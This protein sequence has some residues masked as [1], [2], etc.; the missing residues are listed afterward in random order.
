MGQKLTPS[1]FKKKA[2]KGPYKGRPRKEIA[3]IKIKK[4]LPFTIDK[5]NKLILGVKLSGHLLFYIDGKNTKT[6]SMSDIQKDVDFGGEPK[7]KTA[8]ASISGKIVEVMSEAFFCIYVALKMANT[9][10]KYNKDETYKN[11]DEIQSKKELDD[12]AREYKILPFVETE[13]NSSVFNQYVK[14]ANDFLVDNQWHERL[15]SQ[16]EKFF[17]THSPT[18]QYKLLRA[19][20][21]PKDMD[22]YKV[23]E[24]VAND[25]KAKIGFARPVDK[26][27]WNPADVWFFNETARKTL[28]KELG[29]LNKKLV[30]KPQSSVDYLNDLNQLIF[31][32]FEKKELY[33]ISLKAPKGTS[34][35]ITSVNEDSDIEQVIKFDKVDLGQNNLDVKLRFELIYQK[36]KTKKLID[37]KS[38]YLKSKTDTGGFRLEMEIPGSGARFGSLG[39]ENYQYIIFNTDKTGVNKLLRERKKSNTYS[40]IPDNFKAGNKELTWL[41]AS[42]YQKLSKTKGGA[43]N[44]LEGYMQSLFR[45]LNNAE[46]KISKTRAEKEILNKTIASEIAIAINGI[47]SQLGKEATLENLYSL[48]TSQGLRVGISKEQ[49]VARGEKAKNIVDKNIAQTV[50]DSCF[51]IKIY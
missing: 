18:G 10:N 42:G 26:D 8:S 5:T 7:K 47:T 9:L 27:K 19:D 30:K 35:N 6:I 25:I 17:L 41:G 37:K 15:L 2:S 1:V 11:W 24:V 34:A 28:I 13:L 39:T 49:L 22:P 32:L 4:K 51:H 20:N 48:A 16:V 44:Y 45:K 36:K 46:F 43:K 14:F 12:F 29:N 31:K 38:G 21:L 3:L 33:P 23:Y 50:F 40:S